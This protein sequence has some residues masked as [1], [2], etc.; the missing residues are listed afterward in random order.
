[1][2][3]GPEFCMAVFLEGDALDGFPADEGVVAYEGGAVA[4][5]DGVGDRGVY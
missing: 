1:M 3:L 4:A 2:G 5:S